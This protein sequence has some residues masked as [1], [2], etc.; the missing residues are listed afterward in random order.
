MQTH[1]YVVI[2]PMEATYD[3]QHKDCKNSH[4]IE[5][6]RRMLSSTGFVW[7]WPNCMELPKY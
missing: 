4:N 7:I 6:I 3:E 1:N 5:Q 2:K